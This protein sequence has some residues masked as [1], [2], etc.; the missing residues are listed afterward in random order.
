MTRTWPSSKIPLLSARIPEENMQ[1]QNEATSTSCFFWVLGQSLLPYSRCWSLF[2]K[3]R[4]QAPGRGLMVSAGGGGGEV[5]SP[6]KPYLTPQITNLFKDGYKEIIIRNPKKGRF[7]RVQ[8][9][10]RLPVVEWS[11][12]FLGQTPQKPQKPLSNEDVA[13]LKTAVSIL[14]ILMWW[15]F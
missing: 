4:L 5:S 1:L 13:E 9:N 6:P 15:P 7:F 14:N 3:L 11:S 10:P 12:D 8:V 2:V